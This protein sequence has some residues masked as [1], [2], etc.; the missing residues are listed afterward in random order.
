MK[1]TMGRENAV[2]VVLVQATH[3]YGNNDNNTV[4][5]QIIKPSTLF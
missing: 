3:M 4:N 5:N 1:R 2:V